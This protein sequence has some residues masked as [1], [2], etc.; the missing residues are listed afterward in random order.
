[1][2]KSIFRYN[3]D[4][5]KFFNTMCFDVD[6]QCSISSTPK[7]EFKKNIDKERFFKGTCKDKK[8]VIMDCCPLNL[9]NIAYSPAPEEIPFQIRSTSNG[10]F[11]SCPENVKAGCYRENPKEQPVC[12]QNMCNDSGYR[13]AS[14]FYEICKAQRVGEYLQPP[15][16]CSSKICWG[17]NFTLDNIINKEK[18]VDFDI[19]KYENLIKVKNNLESD[20]KNLSTELI[21]L[22]NRINPN[23]LTLDTDS[24]KIQRKQIIDKMAENEEYMKYMDKLIH[25]SSNASKNNQNNQNNK[26]NKN[27]Q[28][29]FVLDPFST[30]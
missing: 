22:E 28:K 11:E 8:G 1:M 17:K 12:I 4:T 18:L 9:I 16:D 19:F 14:N 3:I 24:M 6:E 21:E 26:N 25:C 10:V 20:Y 30:K 23:D 2:D 29:Y 15:P 27:N 7:M 5:D 13:V